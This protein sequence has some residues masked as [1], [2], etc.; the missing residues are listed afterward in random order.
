[1]ASALTGD[2]SDVSNDIQVCL[3]GMSLVCDI[4][5]HRSQFD[6]MLLSKLFSVV[7]L[8]FGW[9]VGLQIAADMKANLDIAKESLGMLRDDLRKESSHNASQLQ[10]L[11]QKVP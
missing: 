8:L 4:C 11:E 2:L 10:E 5:I 7:C 1:M 9:Q 3:G 6:E